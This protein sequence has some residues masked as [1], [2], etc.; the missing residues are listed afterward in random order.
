MNLK[1][2][3]F[4]Q[5]N[6]YNSAVEKCVGRNSQEKIGRPTFRIIILYFSLYAFLILI[7]QFTCK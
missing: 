5:Y 1:I 6:S 2:R 7:G 3:D 4:W